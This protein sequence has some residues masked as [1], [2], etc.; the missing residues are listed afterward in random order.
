MEARGDVDAASGSAG[1]GDLGKTGDFRLHPVGK[2]GRLG[3]EFFQQTGNEALFL[4]GEGVE[5]VFN[6]DGLVA[7]LGGLGLSRGN[8]FLGVFGE[9]V[10]VHKV[11]LSVKKLRRARG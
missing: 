1:A 11:K 4:G 3:A 2:F 10:Q 5:E 6:L 7:L 8:G 9:F